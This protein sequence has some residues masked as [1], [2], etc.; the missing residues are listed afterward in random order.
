M[1]PLA[2]SHLVRGAVS[3][4]LEVFR[5]L[6]PRPEEVLARAQPVSRGGVNARSSISVWR[7][8]SA[9]AWMIRRPPPIGNALKNDD[10]PPSPCV[11]LLASRIARAAST[12]SS[13]STGQIIA[14]GSR[15]GEAPCR[16]RSHS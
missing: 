6:G 10:A 5:Q 3:Q 8:R 11:G 7:T 15:L 4:A 1:A 12:Y 13:W 9:T 2:L 16:Q 14:P